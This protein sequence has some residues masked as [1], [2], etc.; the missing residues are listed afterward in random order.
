MPLGVV[1]K[2]KEQSAVCFLI[3]L[4]CLKH[5]HSSMSSVRTRDDFSAEVNSVYAIDFAD[6]AFHQGSLPVIFSIDVLWQ[7]FTSFL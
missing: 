1:K 3:P 6:P 5:I 4:R 2:R 7:T